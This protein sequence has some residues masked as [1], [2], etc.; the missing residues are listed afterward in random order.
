M[1]PEDSCAAQRDDASRKLAAAASNSSRRMIM[2]FADL[3]FYQ[4]PQGLKPLING[5]TGGTA[6]A[7]PFPKPVLLQKPT[8][9]ASSRNQI[10]RFSSRSYRLTE[11]EIEPTTGTLMLALASISTG[12]AEA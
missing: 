8:D 10:S 6:E 7:V 2:T 9:E 11:N 5:T 3:R 4:F 1:A 12:I